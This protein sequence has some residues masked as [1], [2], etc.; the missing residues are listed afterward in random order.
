MVLTEV[1]SSSLNSHFIGTEYKSKAPFW[2]L[3][4]KTKNFCLFKQDPFETLI[5][6]I[7]VGAEF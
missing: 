7:S 1:L 3:S 5:S 4:L 2:E 6:N